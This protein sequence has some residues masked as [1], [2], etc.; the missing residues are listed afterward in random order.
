MSSLTELWSNF[1]IVHS[2]PRHSKRQGSV[3]RANQDVQNVLTT[4]MQVHNSAEWSRALRFVQLMKN[5]AVHFGIKRSPYQAMFACP[6]K[7]GL[8]STSLPPKPF[9]HVHSED[10]LENIIH[11][12]SVSSE[13]GIET[14]QDNDHSKSPLQEDNIP[15]GT[16]V[17]N[18]EKESIPNNNDCCLTDLDEST[19]AIKK[20]RIEAYK[21]L[22]DQG[23]RMQQ[24]SDLCFQTVENG[25]TVRV[26]VSDFDRGRGDARSI[27]A[28]ALETTA[29]GLYQIG[30]RDGTIRYAT[31]VTTTAFCL[32]FQFGT[33]PLRIISEQ[34][35]PT[36]ETA[37]LRT[38]ETSQSM[39]S[40][41][42]FFKCN[43]PQKCQTVR[44]LCKN[45]NVLC[46]SKCHVAR[47]CLQ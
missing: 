2:K 13:T 26:P 12:V 47:P 42:A 46:K 5:V 24:C 1:K 17:E 30:T 10:E 18:R 20:H 36:E 31:A 14:L 38:V 32:R 33:C 34:E 7:H 45:K 39:G 29:N 44:C 15:T 16:E 3:E 11:R 4:W 43:Y 27:L 37:A 22:E 23:Q 40:G 9:M 6:P 35:V 8:S 25:C 21:C 41:Q 19:C 28:V